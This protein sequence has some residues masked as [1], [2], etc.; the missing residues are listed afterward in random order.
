MIMRL[1]VAWSAASFFAVKDIAAA[2]AGVGDN[3]L[4]VPLD[5]PFHRLGLARPR[6]K[7]VGLAPV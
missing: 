3:C 5:A 7:S 1:N 2:P 6:R 4:G